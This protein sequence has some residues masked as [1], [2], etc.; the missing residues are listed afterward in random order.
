MDL[1]KAPQPAHKIKMPFKLDENNFKMWAP[2]FKSKAR[3]AHIMGYYSGKF[4][5]PPP[6]SPDFRQFRNNHE[7]AFGV[8]CA[9]LPKSLEHAINIC[10]GQPEPAK[11][12]WKWLERTY[13][14]KK[15]NELHYALQQCRELEMEP[16]EKVG[17]Y[18][19]RA[20]HICQK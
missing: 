7:V 19:I 14:L 15:R 10:G 8:L 4:Q 20:R 13:G 18:I 11:Q 5:P 16:E 2:L 12:L 1:S 3:S 9:L 17:E 6:N